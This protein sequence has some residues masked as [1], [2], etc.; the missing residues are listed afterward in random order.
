MIDTLAPGALRA[1][2]ELGKP[3]W[4]RSAYPTK[5]VIFDKTTGKFMRRSRKGID[6]LIFGEY[7]EP[8]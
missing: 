5:P 7:K 2:P 1:S 3:R 4:L 6:L 8:R